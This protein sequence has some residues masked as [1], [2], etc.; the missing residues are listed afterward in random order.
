M[1]PQLAYHSGG[2]A[3]PHPRASLRPEP[4]T[5]GQHDS[6]AVGRNRLRLQKLYEQP[7]PSPWGWSREGW[8]GGW[9]GSGHWKVTKLC[10]GS[11]LWGWDN[12]QGGRVP[13]AWGWVLAWLCR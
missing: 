9:D 1:V 12:G 4:G 6:W 3:G 5:Q 8:G 13:Q 11:V 7:F 2:R 10:W